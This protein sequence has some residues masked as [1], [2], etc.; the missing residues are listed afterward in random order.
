MQHL[1]VEFLETHIDTW[2]V[3]FRNKYQMQC[4]ID[5]KIYDFK[6]SSCNAILAKMCSKD[7]I[8]KILMVQYVSV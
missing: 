7:C 3:S 4:S 8:L 6:D 1:H 5:E 2:F